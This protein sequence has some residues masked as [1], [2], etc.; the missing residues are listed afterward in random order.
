MNYH[1]VILLS[2]IFCA[3]NEASIGQKKST[4]L[5]SSGM[6]EIGI[7]QPFS[8]PYHYQETIVS[9]IKGDTLHVKNTYP[10]CGD[11][12]GVF[13][14]GLQEEFKDDLEKARSNFALSDKK[15]PKGKIEP[16]YVV[17]LSHEKQS[18]MLGPDVRPIYDP[19]NF[20]IYFDREG[21]IIAAF[22]SKYY[23]VGDTYLHQHYDT[24]TDSWFMVRK[25]CETGEICLLFHTDENA[26]QVE[27]LGEKGN[28]LLQSAVPE[29]KCLNISHIDLS[30][31]KNMKLLRQDGGIIWK[32]PFIRS[33]V[34]IE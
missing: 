20:K 24:W 27:L 25:I 5:F 15:L 18:F 4:G 21:G 8:Q 9:E 10:F 19:Q 14:D 13:N 6:V 3:S 26:T 31:L 7:F 22:C 12:F 23:F 2:L 11:S 17:Q 33:Y 1:S 32:G 34:G 16:F 29:N 28:V 30:E